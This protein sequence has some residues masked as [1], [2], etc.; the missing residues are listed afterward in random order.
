MPHLSSEVLFSAFGLVGTRGLNV[1]DEGV[2]ASL[3]HR[4]HPLKTRKLKRFPYKGVMK[5]SYPERVF[6][7]EVHVEVDIWDGVPHARDDGVAEGH[8]GH[9]VAV[10]HVKVQVVCLAV[11]QVLKKR[12]AC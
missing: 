1:E 12:I 10:H 2:R 8:V 7:H 6:D 11:D 5:F 4:L 3:G 9:E